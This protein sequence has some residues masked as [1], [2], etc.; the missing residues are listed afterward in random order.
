MKKAVILTTG[1]VLACFLTLPLFAFGPGW[2]G[3][4][5]GGG[6]GGYYNCPYYNNYGGTNLTQEQ[7][8]ELNALRNEFRAQ[9]DKIR[10]QLIDRNY[11]LRTELS[12]SVPDEKKAVAIQSDI[13][14][15]RTQMDNARIEHMLKVKK[16]DPDAGAG[17]YGNSGR[18]YGRGCYNREFRGFGPGTSF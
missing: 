3:G 15:L 5:R 7:L 10:D 2:G 17:F 4:M 11:D 18:R 12:K 8:S 6:Y 16:V 13:S 1:I 9:T 14:E